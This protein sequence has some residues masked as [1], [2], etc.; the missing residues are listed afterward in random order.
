MTPPMARLLRIAWPVPLIVAYVCYITGPALAAGF[1]INDDHEVPFYL[2]ADRSITWD[3]TFTAIGDNAL[4]WNNRVLAVHYVVRMIEM[5]LRGF[6]P[7]GYHL[8]RTIMGCLCA[9]SVYA[10]SACFLK[11]VGAA[12]YLAGAQS[13]LFIN[14]AYTET[15]GAVLALAGAALVAVGVRR[16]RDRPAQLWPGFTLILLSAGCKESFVPLLPAALAIVY[17][18]RVLPGSPLRRPLGW[19]GTDWVVLA[20]LVGASLAVVA[21]TLA[22]LAVHGH[23]YAGTMTTSQFLDVMDQ[24]TLGTWFETY[25]PVA[26][27]GALYAI[28]LTRHAHP[29]PLGERIG[30]FAGAIA[31]ALVLLVLPQAFIFGSSH[32]FFPRYLAPGHFFAVFV[33]AMGL[34]VIQR[35]RRGRLTTVLSAIVSFCVVGASLVAA[36]HMRATAVDYTK[37]TRQFASQIASIERLAAEHPDSPIIFHGGDPIEIEAI[38]STRRFLAVGPAGDT[39]MF[40]VFPRYAGRD[41]DPLGTKLADPLERWSAHGGEGFLPLSQRPQPAGD[42]CIGLAFPGAHAIPCRHTVSLYGLRH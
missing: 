42:D 3:E 16:G 36:T 29:A 37:A 28:W 27:L 39:P 8:N 20:A 33:I 34:W 41:S 14:L 17:L 4:T 24:L 15:T 23:Q 35:N 38:V 2:G 7:A 13:R 12:A 30:W 21:A 9:L 19:R 31:G 10:A 26:V 11:P 40:L 1:S 5:K 32:L 6:D 22:L 25:W 18:P